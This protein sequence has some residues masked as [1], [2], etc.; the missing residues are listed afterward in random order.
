MENSFAA[1]YENKDRNIYQNFV[2][3][4]KECSIKYSEV[5]KK[6][7]SP[8]IAI[9]QSSGF[10]KSRLQKELSDNEFVF[11]INFTNSAAA[12]PPQSKVGNSLLSHTYTYVETDTFNPN[13]FICMFLSECVIFATKNKA[14]R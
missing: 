11:Y 9:F 7:Y 1:P 5:P 6:F 13:A 4:L 2:S 8:Y 12:F 3:Y 10:G 14:S